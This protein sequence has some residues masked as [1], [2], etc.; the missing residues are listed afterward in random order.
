M[1]HHRKHPRESNRMFT[2][3]GLALYI[4]RAKKT[5]QQN[6]SIEGPRHHFGA[7]R[8]HWL[9]SSLRMA[10]RELVKKRHMR[11]ENFD[12]IGRSFTLSKLA[13]LELREP[14]ENMHFLVCIAGKPFLYFN[15]RQITLP[16]PPSRSDNTIDIHV[17]SY[18]TPKS[19]TPRRKSIEKQRKSWNLRLQHLVR[20]SDYT[21]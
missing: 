1:K 12:E 5:S 6:R 15:L 11:S 3:F 2:G 9:K 19:A 21:R 17:P 20:D 14:P 8:S 4:W 13:D 16:S 18:S 10:E 7:I